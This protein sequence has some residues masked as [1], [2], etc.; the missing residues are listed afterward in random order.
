LTAG[1]TVF[2]VLVTF[3]GYDKFVIGVE[4]EL[5]LDVCDILVSKGCTVDFASSLVLGPDTDNGSN[6]EHRRLALDF[7]SLGKGFNNCVELNVS[8]VSWG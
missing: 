6:V 3:L 2:E 5:S 7:L 8:E 1:N 4:T